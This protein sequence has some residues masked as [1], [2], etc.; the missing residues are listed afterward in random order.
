MKRSFKTIVSSLALLGLLSA[1]GSSNDVDVNLD[2]SMDNET[3]EGTAKI[4]AQDMPSD[5]PEDAPGAY[6][7]STVSYSASMDPET[8]KPDMAI[9]STTADN[10][11]TVTTH[12]KT[13]LAAKG[14]T[15]G[16][17]MEGAGTSI[18]SAT[19]DTRT[20]SL[21]ITGTGQGQTTVTMAIEIME[22][23]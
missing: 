13:E 1:C 20:M 15:V 19:K 4:G 2:G 12:Y 10:T 18:F 6:P 9:V 23:E 11:A 17:R 16:T 7:G 8:G 5:W 14:W 22:A 21:L 3:E